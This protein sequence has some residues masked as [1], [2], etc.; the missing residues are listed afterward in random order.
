MDK[1][2]KAIRKG[3]SSKVGELLQ[4]RGI[5]INGVDPKSG[6]TMLQ[7]AMENEDH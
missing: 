5:N 2:I 1:L 7:L 6:K 4:D 3:D